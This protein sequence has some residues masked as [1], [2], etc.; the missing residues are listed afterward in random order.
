VLFLIYKG[1]WSLTVPAIWAAALV[2]LALSVRRR[3][4]GVVLALLACTPLAAL[5]FPP[6][7]N[8]LDRA[9]SAS[10]KSTIRPGLEYD[11]AIVLG[12]NLFR[13]QAGADVVRRGQARYLLYTGALDSSG[14]QRLT[15]ELVAR[16]VPAERIVI[17]SRSRNTR[18]NAI[19][20]SRIV[21]ARHWRSLL[22]VTGTAHVERAVGCFRGLGLTPDVLP[23]TE[24][25]PI[26]GVSPR[27][28]ALEHAADLL[29]E[30]VGR[31]VYRIRGCS[32]G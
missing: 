28:D 18:E 1:L 11:A 7:V 23:V 12:G 17:E 19:E 5:T 15:S 32:D 25:G 16:G 14:I 29:H 24:F 27:A 8:A 20:S 4:L 31:F 26:E 10:G 2:A 30:I 21:V 3:S 6:V 13:I 22:L 9:V